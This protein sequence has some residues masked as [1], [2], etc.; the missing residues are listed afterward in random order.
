MSQHREIF[1]NKEKL[2]HQMHAELDMTTHRCSP[3]QRY[4]TTYPESIIMSF[5]ATPSLPKIWSLF[6]NPTF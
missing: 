2:E 1:V 5:K 4:R 6:G 3:S